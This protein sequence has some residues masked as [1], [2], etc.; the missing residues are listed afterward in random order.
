MIAV[1]S[2][3]LQSYSLLTVYMVSVLQHTC[4]HVQG[5]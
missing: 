1:T 2:P 3:C 4:L 5:Y